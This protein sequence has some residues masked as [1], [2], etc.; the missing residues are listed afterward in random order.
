MRKLLR[1]TMMGILAAGLG[2]NLAGCSDEATS[3][4]TATVSGPD[5][6]TKVTEKTT[7]EKSGNN[8]PPAKAP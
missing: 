1:L 6:K 5:G 2:L 8:P 4:R 7:V 3:E